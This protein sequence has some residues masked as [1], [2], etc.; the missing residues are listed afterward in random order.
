MKNWEEEKDA[1]ENQNASRAE[2]VWKGDLLRGNRMAPFGEEK[3]KG[4]RKILA[5]RIE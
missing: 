1:P 5:R 2:R 4:T 3:G